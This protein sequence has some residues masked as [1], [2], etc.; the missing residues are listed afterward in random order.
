ML[1]LWKER[2]QSKQQEGIYSPLRYNY[3]LENGSFL[4]QWST[5][6]VC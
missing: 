6:F 1:Q 2:Y 5:Y 4:I 3:M